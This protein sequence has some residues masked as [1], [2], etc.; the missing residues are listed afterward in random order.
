MRAR[1]VL[2]AVLGVALA[3]TLTACTAQGGDPTAGCTDEVRSAG[4]PGDAEPLLVFDSV[5]YNP[6]VVYADGAVVVPLSSDAA[7]G[8]AGAA[9][10]VPMMAPGYM[11][12]QPGGYVGGWLSDCELAAVIEAADE[13]FRPGL[14]FGDPQVTDMGGTD[15]AYEG[16]TIGVYAF[17]RDDP[18]EWSGLTRSEQQARQDLADLWN[19]V[20]SAATLTGELPIDRLN[21][22]LMGSVDDD[23]LIDWPLDDP[24]SSFAQGSY[25]CVTITDPDDVAALVDRL[26]D[27]PLLADGEYRL[28]IVAA[29]PGTPACSG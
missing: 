23:E 24:L 2:G 11:G 28:A 26:D 4:E 29:A 9:L 10:R 20:E 7:Q 19:G 15:V 1:G 14:D 21:I 16:H 25:D 12:D 17:S 22:H 13:L 27:G 6:T 18:T 8:V 3:A 5:H